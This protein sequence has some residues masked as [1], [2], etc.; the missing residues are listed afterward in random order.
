MQSTEHNLQNINVHPQV[1]SIAQDII[2]YTLKGQIWTSKHIL[3]TIHN[4]TGIKSVVILINHLGHGISY[5]EL[6]E[7]QTAMT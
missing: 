5:T 4:M 7:L 1:V 2:Y 6:E 3:L